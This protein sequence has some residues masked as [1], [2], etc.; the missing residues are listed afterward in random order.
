L[1]R[2]PASSRKQGEANLEGLASTIRIALAVPLLNPGDLLHNRAPE[3]ST[4]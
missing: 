1:L 4:E 2:D 3:Q